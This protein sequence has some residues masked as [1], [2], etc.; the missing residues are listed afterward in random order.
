ME[1]PGTQTNLPVTISGVL[2]GKKFDKRFQVPFNKALR[3]K[4]STMID[5]DGLAVAEITKLF[6][7]VKSSRIINKL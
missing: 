5:T 3:I 2:N 7:S 1:N 6:G 4:P